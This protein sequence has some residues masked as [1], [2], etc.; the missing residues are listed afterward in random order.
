MPHYFIVLK[1][2]FSDD[3]FGIGNPSFTLFATDIEFSDIS[4][5]CSFYNNADVIGICDR[6]NILKLKYY[7]DTG[8]FVKDII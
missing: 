8:K 5:T 6:K 1:S 7:D 4:D 3:D 2:C